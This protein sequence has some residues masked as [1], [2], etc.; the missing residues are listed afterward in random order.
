MKDA[1]MQFARMEVL[2]IPAKGG[3]DDHREGWKGACRGYMQSGGR[4]CWRW[5]AG[6]GL[7]GVWAVGEKE[8][9]ETR[10]CSVSG[11]QRRILFLS[12]ER[13]KTKSKLPSSEQLQ[14]AHNIILCSPVAGGDRRGPTVNIALTVHITFC[15]LYEFRLI[16]FCNAFIFP[17]YFH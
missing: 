9:T 5:S 11:N 10:V 4:V 8:L 6:R 14:L 7:G 17:G 3:W 12:D 1:S 2:V 15:F 13:G 16:W